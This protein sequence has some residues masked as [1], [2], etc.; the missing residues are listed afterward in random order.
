MMTIRRGPTS[1]AGISNTSVWNQDNFSLTKLVLTNTELIT[2]IPSAEVDVVV[3]GRLQQ[4]ALAGVAVLSDEND[5]DLG[6]SFGA[7]LVAGCH[8]DLVRG[9]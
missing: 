2:D 1:T 9:D 5:E 4:H 8:R 3:V 6:R 7:R